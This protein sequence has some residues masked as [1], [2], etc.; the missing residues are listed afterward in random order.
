MPQEIMPYFELHI[1]P[2]FRRLDRENMLWR[3]DL[4]NYDDVRVGNAALI[5]SVLRRPVG[6]MMPPLDRGGPWPEEWIRVFERWT[7]HG[8]PRLQLATG[9]P[10][11][12]R[13]QD[14]YVVLRIAV[15]LVDG[16]GDVWVDR[17][18][19]PPEVAAYSLYLRPTQSDT[20]TRASPIYIE[21]YI[22]DPNV[23]IVL[24]TDATGQYEIPI[25]TDETE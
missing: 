1:R 4:W 15:D 25:V 3:L 16:S 18:E 19:S 24:L 22:T 2:L 12:R 21:E 14:G 17:D 13:L 10:S 23:S 11:A 5:A 9:S 7:L 6:Q 8:C 20:A